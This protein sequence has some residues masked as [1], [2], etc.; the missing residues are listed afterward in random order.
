MSEAFPPMG[1]TFPKVPAQAA[2]EIASASKA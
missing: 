2:A 1:I